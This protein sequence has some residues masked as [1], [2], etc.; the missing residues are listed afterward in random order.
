M[1]NCGIDLHQKSSQVTVVDQEG[2]V[3][4]RASIP[5]TRTGLERWFGR[6]E[7]MRILVEASGSSPWVVRLLLE[8][9]HEV[10]VIDPRRVRLIAQ[11]TLKTDRID[12]DILAEL[13][14][15]R[16]KL[17]TLVWQ[18]S[19]TTQR[20]RGHLRVRRALVEA[21][22]GFI[23][24][25]RGLLRSFGVRVASCRSDRFAARCQATA[26]PPKLAE[27]MTPLL[28]AIH[29]LDARIATMDAVVEQVGHLYPAVGS[30][31][32]IPGVGPVVALAYVL[33]I[34]DPSRFHRSRDVPGY[35][36]LRPT[37]RSSAATV[38]QGRITKEGDADVRRLL[39]QAAHAHLRSHADTAL[40]SWA[41]SLIPRIGKRKTIVA[42]ARKLAVL[43]HRLWITGEVYQPFP[44]DT[45]KA[46]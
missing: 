36:G 45:A 18:R 33:S 3:L 22:A 28:D 27:V 6:R 10:E 11:S 29:D 39:V 12:A 35:L 46:A 25:V 2:E 23:V 16:T 42:L 30:L 43:M 37:L 40:K 1:E 24:T 9:G 32:D 8:L 4:E 31:Q 21:R 19:E 41:E 7:R 26:I 5:T 14:R 20:Q 44:H 38:R 15:L 34:E 17:R 13:A